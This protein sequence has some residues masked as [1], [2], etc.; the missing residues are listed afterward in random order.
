MNDMAELNID[1]ALVGQSKL[2]QRGE[3]LVGALV[4]IVTICVSNSGG[5]AV[6]ACSPR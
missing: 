5:A 1:G 3:K 6:P 4:T 2:I